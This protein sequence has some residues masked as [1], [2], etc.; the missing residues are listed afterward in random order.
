M[1]DWGVAGNGICA[2]EQQ[3]RAIVACQI[4]EKEGCVR[5]MYRSG[6]AGLI[7]QDTNR[8]LSRD[9]VWE[10]LPWVMVGPG[11]PNGACVEVG[12]KL[13]VTGGTHPGRSFY[14]FHEPFKCKLSLKGPKVVQLPLRS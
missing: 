5:L 2:L 14:N 6:I 7:H 9:M 4:T 10:Q 8:I 3:G 12:G 1:G 13:W 11:R